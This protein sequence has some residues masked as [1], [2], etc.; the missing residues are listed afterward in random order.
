VLDGLRRVREQKMLG[1]VCAGLGRHCDLD[2]VIFRIVLAVL[3]LTG[4]LGLI[5]Y[6]LFWLFV[7]FQGEEEN[8]ARR[9]LSGRVDGVTLTAVLFALVGCGL[10]LSMLGNEGVLTFGASVAKLLAGAGYWARRRGALDADPQVA[11]D[12][13]PE[14]QAPP[15]PASYPAWW[16]DPIVKDGTHEGGTGYLWGPQDMRDLNT[17]RKVARTSRWDTAPR[18]PRHPAPSGPHWIGGWVFLL[19]LLAGGAGTGLTWRTE[20]LGTSLQTGLA[21]ALAVFGLGIAIS[22]LLGRTGAGS[23]LLAV[24][25]AAL[26][27]ASSAVPKNITTEWIRTTWRPPT[28]AQVHA[29]YGLGTGDGTLDLSRIHVAKGRVVHSH[30]EV[31]AGRLKVVVPKDTT[32]RLHVVVDLGDIQLPGE[33][34]QDVDVAPGK[35]KDVTLHP[36]RGRSPGGTLDLS[37]NV[38]IGQVE[39]TRAAA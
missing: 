1:G 4:G 15:V 30:A 23:I 3:S 17:A 8:E 25:T 24:I 13:P 37:L 6:G 21:A 32:V 11:A 36:S 12:A 20:A 9:L 14:A 33:G 19:A 28:A 39:V 18:P 26:L 2:P 27:A 35:E 10:F 31:G 34:R 38:A 7:P 16:R 5:F 22:A 29:H